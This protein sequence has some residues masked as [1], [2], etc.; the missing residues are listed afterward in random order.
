MCFIDAYLQYGVAA[1]GQQAQQI[2]CEGIKWR[3]LR[4][5]VPISI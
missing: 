3:L 5:D 1:K 2:A 4:Q